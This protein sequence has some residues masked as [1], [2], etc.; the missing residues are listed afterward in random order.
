MG[1]R[2]VTANSSEKYNVIQISINYCQYL[3]I[4]IVK[5]FPEA[6]PHPDTT[7]LFALPTAP[8]VRL[9]AMT[10]ALLFS[11]VT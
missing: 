3:M 11:T 6:L 5:L 9:R 4:P 1:T 2:D 7:L 8:T 10:R